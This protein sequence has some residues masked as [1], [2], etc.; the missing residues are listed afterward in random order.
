MDSAKETFEAEKKIWQQLNDFQ[1]E[2]RFH[3]NKSEFIMDTPKAHRAIKVELDRR[4]FSV[5]KI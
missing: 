2:A 4:E 3:I 1:D 5:K